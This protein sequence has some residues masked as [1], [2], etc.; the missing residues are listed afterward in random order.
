MPHGECHAGGH[1]G[2]P[3]VPGE[4]VAQ[5]LQELEP[6]QQWAAE[7]DEDRQLIAQ[8]RKR[9]PWEPPA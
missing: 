4:E 2:G 3:W 5:L 1:A 9:D 6:D 7:L 8:Q